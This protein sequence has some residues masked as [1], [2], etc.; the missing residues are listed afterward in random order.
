[1]HLN[2]QFSVISHKASYRGKLN[3]K[4]AGAEFFFFGGGE[5]SEVGGP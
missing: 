2:P 3:T 4:F 5:A 1:M